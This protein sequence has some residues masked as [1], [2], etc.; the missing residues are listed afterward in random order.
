MTLACFTILHY[1]TIQE[2]QKCV[3]SLLKIS[4]IGNCQI[5]IYDNASKDGSVEL[6]KKNYQKYSNISI[7]ESSRNG[8]YSKGNNAAYTIAKS[9]NPKFIIAMNNDVQ[10][11]QK[12]FLVKLEGIALRDDFFLIGP[13]VY[14]PYSHSHQSP[15]YDTFPTCEQTDKEMSIYKTILSDIDKQIPIERKKRILNKVRHYVPK[16]VVFAFRG[17]KQASGIEEREK[18]ERYKM[19]RINPVLQGS[20]IIVTELYLKENDVLFE[21]DTRFYFEELLLALKCK[22]LNYKTIYTPELQV[23]H[24]HGAATRKSTKTIR[25]FLRFNAENML[26]AYD[27]YR[28]AL[29]DNPWQKNH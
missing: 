8:G 17:L 27:I 4:K 26:R 5:I 24:N 15:L 20:C 9:Y 29:K 6:L 11:H 2:T 25:D 13:D 16:T 1:K 22:T 14:A 10:I 18:F 12:D 28:K 19:E 21:P 3:G 7:Y 23:I